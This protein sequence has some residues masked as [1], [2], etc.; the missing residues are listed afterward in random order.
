MRFRVKTG[1]VEGHW[2]GWLKLCRGKDGRDSL[3]YGQRAVHV[4]MVEVQKR[5]RAERQQILYQLVHQ[6]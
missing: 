4:S 3:E 6:I 2:M 5:I 1:D